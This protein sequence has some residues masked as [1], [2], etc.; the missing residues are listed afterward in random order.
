MANGRILI[1]SG[2]CLGEWALEE[3][4]EGDFLLG[5]DRGALFLLRNN[6]QPNFALGDFDSVTKDEFNEIQ[7]FSRGISC[8]DAVKKDHTDTEMAFNWALA[9]RPAEIVLMG[10]TGT[11]LDHTLA[12]IHLLYRGLSAGVP[13]RIIGEKNEII[14]IDK[15]ASVARGRFA[16][17]S[18]LPLSTEVTGITLEGFQYPLYKHTIRM[19]ESVGIS[20]I[21]VEETG[22]VH[23]DSGL[24]LVM[25]SLD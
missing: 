5:A 1:F 24:L 25:K 17:V 16:H 20:N 12:N 3:I 2:G 6:L 11:R 4:Q 22:A 19:G 10:V 21:L 9:Q 18:L 23:I 13:C 7:S 15:S 8:C 14:L